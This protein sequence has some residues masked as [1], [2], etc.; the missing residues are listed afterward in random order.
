MSRRITIAT[1]MDN[2]ELV[3][4]SLNELNAEFSRKNDWFQIRSVGGQRFLYTGAGINVKTQEVAY[5]ED[6]H[7]AKNFVT[8]KLFQVY[9]KNKVLD[10]MI[11]EGQEIL[12]HYTAEAGTH[13]EG[14]E[15]II[16]EGDIV[17]LT[18]TAF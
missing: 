7:R 6:D 8:N 16:E 10:N 11:L 14:C 18:E 2:E 9:N 17:I 13:I 15:D 1:K 4:Q 5:D 3:E 12:E